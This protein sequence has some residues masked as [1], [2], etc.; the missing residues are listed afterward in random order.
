M[1]VSGGAPLPKEIYYAFTK[2]FPINFIEGYGLTEAA[3]VVSINPVAGIKKPGSIGKPLPDI[4][5]I[6]GD[7]QGKEV[8]CGEVGEILV[9]GENVM[10]GYYKD[11]Q[12]ASEAF[13][14]GWLRT[15]DMGLM[16]E[17]G[18]IFIVDRKKDII[19][20]SGFNVYPREIED[21]L[22]SHPQIEEAAVIGVPDE[23]RGEVP[24]VFIV[25]KEGEEIDKKEVLAFLKP[26]LAQYKLPR[27]IEIRESLPK[28]AAGKIL[29]KFLK[30]E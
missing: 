4:E 20:V 10:Q 17:D 6:I 29:K 14:N 1:A 27:E 5:V 8:A 11:E 12:A 21:L 25:P 22:Y 26:K 28:N 2:K 15:G 18:Y 13:V 7:E 19:I 30:Q 3:P 16:D 23:T 24:K 9:K